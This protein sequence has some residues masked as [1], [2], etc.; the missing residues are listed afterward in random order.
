MKPRIERI[1]VKRGGPLEKDF[2]IQPGDLNLIYGLNETGKTYLVESLVRLLFKTQGRDAPEWKL[3]EWDANG[4][5]LVS[6]IEEE[7]QATSFGKTS[8]KLEDYRCG[9]DDHLPRDFSRLL[10]VRAGETVLSGDPGEDGINRDILKDYLSEERLLDELLERISITIQGAQVE[11]KAI[12]GDNRGEVR[13]QKGLKKGVSNLNEL[14][15][16]V[17]QNFSEGPVS[18]LRKELEA[19]QEMHEDLGRARRHQAYLL[20]SN[21]KDLEE[22]K[23]ALEG[24]EILGEM[25]SSIDQY[26]GKVSEGVLL[27]KELKELQ[28]AV[29]KRQWCEEALKN[30]DEIVNRR[31]VKG[32]ERAWG[33][34]AACALIASVAG[35]FIG[36]KWLLG[37]GAVLSLVCGWIFSRKLLGAAPVAASD[38]VELKR[39]DQQYQEHFGKALGDRASLTKRIGSLQEDL[40]KARAKQDQLDKSNSAAGKLRVRIDGFFLQAGFEDL[41]SSDWRKTLAEMRASHRAIEG[42]ITGCAEKLRDLLVPVEEDLEGDPGI[43]WDPGR[44]EDLTT[45]VEQLETEIELEDGRLDDLKERVALQVGS[46]VATGWDLLLDSLQEQKESRLREY[47]ECTADILA[48]IELCRVL[49][50]MRQKETERIEQGLKKDDLTDPL[51]SLTGKRYQSIHLDG[52]GGLELGDGEGNYYALGKLSTGVREQICLALRFGFASI[53]L[54]GPAFLLLDDAFQHSD[55][56]RRPRMIEY[57]VKLVNQGWQVFYFTMDDHIRDQFEKVGQV[58][59]SDRFFSMDLGAGDPAFAG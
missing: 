25:E 22:D 23:P 41:D 7:G 2:E 39:M 12:V 49:E 45:E 31:S 28:D 29:G 42:K 43:A 3:R 30:Y 16:E 33:I 27:E 21:L 51:S 1:K 35:G 58:L 46:R 10:V 40:G 17:K 4:K 47:R 57:V 20:R 34:G 18:I 37:A 53:A 6:G 50:G 9:E 14:L 59:G 5:I 15:E 55:W 11:E 52:E 38:N 54:G 26:D 24:L 13:K 36:Q 32:Q 56:K 48:K 19:R 8:K 44:F